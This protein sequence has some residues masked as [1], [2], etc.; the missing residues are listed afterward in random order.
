[1]LTRLVLASAAA[2]VVS[3]SPALAAAVNF[4]NLTV[5]NNPLT[6]IP[7]NAPV[8]GTYVKFVYTTNWSYNSGT[9]T[10]YNASWYVGNPVNSIVASFS[11]ISGMANNANPTT[12]TISGT[13]SIGVTNANS[14]QFVASQNPNDIGQFATSANWS[15]TTLNFYVQKPPSP[16]PT[17]VINMGAIHPATGQQM[18]VDTGGSTF[19]PTVGVFSDDGYLIAS[20]ADGGTGVPSTALEAMTLRSGTYYV[21]ACGE[22]SIFG[23]EDL[24]VSVPPDAPGGD[25]GG[26]ING[27]PWPNPA[28]ATGE[29]QWF[30]FTVAP[31]ACIGD[32]TGDG[33]TNSADF[34]VM[35]SNFG[36]TVFPFTGGDLTG[37]G[38]V[39]SADF[40]VLATDFGCGS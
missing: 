15:G 17:G 28:V 26:G 37:D 9:P 3:A 2:S 32:I 39:N 1:M 16:I 34:N 25:L 11:S 18:T 27:I 24:D 20:N 22:G 4:G 30:S 10:S 8:G 35:A 31:P 7:F 6:I 21:C 36:L 14:L 13:F 38:L 5:Y 23:P 19:N 33:I 12:I 40:N 29:P